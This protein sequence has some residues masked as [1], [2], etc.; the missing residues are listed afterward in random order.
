[1]KTKTI[2]RASSCGPLLIPEKLACENCKMSIH[3]ANQK[4]IMP[5]HIKKCLKP[6]DIKWA[7]H[8]EAGKV[9]KYH[10]IHSFWNETVSNFADSLQNTNVYP[11]KKS[12]QTNINN[13]TTCTVNQEENLI[14][15]LK[16]NFNQKETNPT[17]LDSQ[18]TASELSVEVREENDSH[19]SSITNRGEVVS[20]VS[21][22]E[23]NTNAI[24]NHQTVS[25]TV[26]KTHAVIHK[27]QLSILKEKAKK[28]DKLMSVLSAPQYEGCEMGNRM[29]GFASSCIPQA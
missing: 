20:V 7:N 11:S 1:M 24:N 21:T 27:K 17:T 9:R 5:R 13:R 6:W 10:E 12:A 14:V 8:R 28:Y 3:K 29:L 19:Q 23:N 15:R 16:F 22:N 4:G 18:S 25:N 26:P 2:T